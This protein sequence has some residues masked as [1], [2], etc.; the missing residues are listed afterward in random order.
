[1]PSWKVKVKAL[2]LHLVVL[3][4]GKVMDCVRNEQKT[5]V[6]RA[7]GALETTAASRLT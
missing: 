2:G 7:T 1:M 3:K 5:H 4:M 6:S